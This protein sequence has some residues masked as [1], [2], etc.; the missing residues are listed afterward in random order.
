MKNKSVMTS[1][2]VNKYLSIYIIRLLVAKITFA[3]AEITIKVAVINYS[4]VKITFKKWLQR[5]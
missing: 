5:M 4:V 1:L 3:A 2:Y